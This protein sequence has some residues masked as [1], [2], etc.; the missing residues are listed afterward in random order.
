MMHSELKNKHSIPLTMWEDKICA[1]QE[2]ASGG[3]SGERTQGVCRQN[4]H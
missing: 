3:V 2:N 1:A 4:R